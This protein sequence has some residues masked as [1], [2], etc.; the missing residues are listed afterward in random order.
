MSQLNALHEVA[1]ATEVKVR[2]VRV[3]QL[4]QQFCIFAALGPMHLLFLRYF[5]PV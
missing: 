3:R 5:L 1:R 4:H 2:E